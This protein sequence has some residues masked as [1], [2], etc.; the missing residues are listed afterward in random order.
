MAAL[1][2]GCVLIFYYGLWKQ[3]A[4][5]LPVRGRAR[6]AGL[7]SWKQTHLPDDTVPDTQFLRQDVEAAVPQNKLL[8]IDAAI[9]P[10][11]FFRVQFYLRSD[12]LLLH[13]LSYLRKQKNSR[14]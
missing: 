8:A 14:P 2:N 5:W 11:D 4:R 7:F 9:G 3:T 13:N 12:A 6:M 10:L 1:L